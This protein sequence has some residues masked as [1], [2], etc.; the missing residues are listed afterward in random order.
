MNRIFSLRSTTRV[1]RTVSVDAA[2]YKSAKSDYGGLQIRRDGNRLLLMRITNPP[3][4]AGQAHV[5]A[6]RIRPDTPTYPRGR[7]RAYA[8]RPYSQFGK[9]RTFKKPKVMEEKKKNVWS[10]VLKV[11]IAVAS[12]VAGALGI[13]AC[14]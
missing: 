9:M 11:I 13:S 4:R 2:D 5:G 14:M 12:A 7:F 1:I 10:I 6:Y 3:W 8:I